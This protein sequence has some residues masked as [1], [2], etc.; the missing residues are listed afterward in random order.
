M[1]DAENEIVAN[2]I[3]Y[4]PLIIQNFEYISIGLLRKFGLYILANLILY[5]VTV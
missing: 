1:K 3:S 4:L 2:D 5:G